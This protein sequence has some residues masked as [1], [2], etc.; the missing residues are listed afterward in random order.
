M[1]NQSSSKSISGATATKNDGL[2]VDN[3]GRRVNEKGYL[4]DDEGNIID[5]HGKKLWDRK[6][7]KNGEF[8]KIFAFTKFNIKNV[9]GDFEM[10]PVGDP[11]ITEIQPGHWV[12][13][14]NRRVN[15][16][17]YLIDAD[18]NV[19]DKRGYKMFDK[20]ILD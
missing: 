17:G 12:D 7:L 14:K 8:P 15:K 20:A 1:M 6:H 4:I 10:N 5:I 19:I 13:D 11:M 3:L 16:R 18:G 2:L 9:L